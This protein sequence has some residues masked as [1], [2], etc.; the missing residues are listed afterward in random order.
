MV[1]ITDNSSEYTWVTT[2]RNKKA[3]TKRVEFSFIPTISK[4]KPTQRES[5]RGKT[6]IS[7]FQNFLKLINY[8]NNQ[9]FVMEAP[10]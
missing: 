10:E 3:Q 5:E 4:R 1:V 7:V 8:T 2:L 6:Y 9:A